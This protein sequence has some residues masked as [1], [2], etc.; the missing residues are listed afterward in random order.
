MK[1]TNVTLAG[2]PITIFTHYVKVILCSVVYLREM[3]SLAPSNSSSC[4]SVGKGKQKCHISFPDDLNIF[5]EQYTPN[6][7][8]FLS[9]DHLKRTL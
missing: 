1:E 6:P 2:F 7:S 5:T 9:A 8:S 4:T 3:D